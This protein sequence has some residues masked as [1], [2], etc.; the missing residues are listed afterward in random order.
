MAMPKFRTRADKDKANELAASYTEKDLEDELI[1]SV[2]KM[3][4][5]ATSFSTHLSED[6]KQLD[7]LSKLQTENKE[8]GE[9]NIDKIINFQKLSQDLSFFRLLKMAVIS[10]ILFVATAGFIFVDSFLF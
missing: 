2:G 7:R 10:I 4:L 9:Y 5:Y 3:K 8:S 6:A 1:N